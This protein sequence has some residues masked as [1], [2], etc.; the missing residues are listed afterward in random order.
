MN[1]VPNAG[2]LKQFGLLALRTSNIMRSKQEGIFGLSFTKGSIYIPNITY[3][4]FLTV[5]A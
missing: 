3:F 2:F 4:Y 1:Q 5:L